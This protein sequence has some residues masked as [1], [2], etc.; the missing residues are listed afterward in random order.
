[1]KHYHQNMQNCLHTVEKL[2]LW[3]EHFSSFHSN[4]FKLRCIYYVLPGCLPR[5]NSYPSISDCRWA[6]DIQS[7]RSHRLFHREKTCDRNLRAGCGYHLPITKDIFRKLCLLIDQV[8]NSY[9]EKVLFHCMYLK[10][11]CQAIVFIWET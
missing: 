4:S 3:N 11:C 10:N 5:L 9:Y 1:M 8:A 6:Q 2:N 7:G